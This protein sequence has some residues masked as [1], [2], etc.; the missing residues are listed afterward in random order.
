MTCLA[1]VWALP[2]PAAATTATER[3]KDGNFDG[4]ECD[5]SECVDLYW[6]QSGSASFGALIGPLCSTGVPDCDTNNS[7]YTTPFGWARLGAATEAPNSDADIV[8]SSI[9]EP[10]EV[11][12]SLP[13]DALATLHFN[14]RIR[15]SDNESDETMTVSLNGTPV[16]SVNDTDTRYTG[17]YQPVSVPL[18]ALV[19]PGEKT[20]RFEASGTFRHISASFDIDEVSVTAPDAVPAPSVPVPSSGS[21]PTAGPKA[22]KCKKKTKKGRGAASAK[23]RCKKKR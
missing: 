2:A 5:S 3:A 17:N 22:K 14:L 23:K 15:P 13:P 19:G 12:A 6:A 1:V 21:Q 4:E 11:P 16:L 9:S 8:D 18:D 10:I 7:G 20:L